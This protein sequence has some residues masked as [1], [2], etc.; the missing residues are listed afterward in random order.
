MRTRIVL[1]LVASLGLAGCGGDRPPA[2]PADA[3]PAVEEERLAVVAALYPLAWAAERVGGGRVEVTNLTPPGADPHDV[4]LSAR[5]VGRVHDADLVLYLG[6]GFQPAL[7]RILAGAT[8]RRVD[9]LEGLELRRGI[10]HDHDH[11]H[12]EDDEDDGGVDPHVWLDPLRFA[13]MEI[14]SRSY[15]SAR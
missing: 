5:D 14:C 8:T 4:E 9:L 2:A 11:G 6:D 7:E 1:T 3:S 10:A 15:R 12:G 13:A